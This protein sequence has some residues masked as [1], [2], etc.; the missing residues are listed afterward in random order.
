MSYK[1]SVQS[2]PTKQSNS[3]EIK[4]LLLNDLFETHWYYFEEIKFVENEGGS[5]NPP[6]RG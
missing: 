1:R 3:I 6:V 5:T 2:R 4:T